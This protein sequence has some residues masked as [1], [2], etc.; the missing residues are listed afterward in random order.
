MSEQLGI[1]AVLST[2]NRCDLLP[3]ALE[4]LLSQ[5][6]PHQSYEVIVV[7]NNSTD[8]T[9]GVIE[10]F[11]ARSG[12]RMRYVFEGR[13]GLSYGR[14]AG[15][16][17]ARAP[18]VAFTDD[19][20]RP[21]PGWLAAVKRAFDEHPEVDVVGGKV[22]P[23]W[24]AEPPAWLTRDQWTVLALQDHGAE[25]FVV[26]AARP[27]VLVGANF[28]FR[29]SVFDQL[30]LFS[31]DFPRSQDLEMLVRVWRSGRRGLYAPDALVLADV[32]PERLTKAYHRSWHR[33]NGKYNALM[34]LGELVGPDGSVL[35]ASL[36]SVKLFGAPAFIYRELAGEGGSWLR[37]AARG[38]RNESFAHG[39][40]VA[41]L[42]GYIKSCYDSYLPERKRSHVAEVG[43]FLGAMLR[44]KVLHHPAG[45]TTR[46]T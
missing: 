33:T 11:V 29:R 5:D 10:R 35:E 22:L 34:R 12:G 18:I 42:T 15:L 37:A 8:A 39:N 32:Q 19:D 21:S 16:L 25:P 3:G 20:V 14:N 23:A 9:R 38:R 28:A 43:A 17:G 31:P 26:D 45:A 41:F 13:Q 6:L 2:Y 40:R 44:K 27:V 24:Q 30:G 1:T 7:D 4:A 46:R 36:D